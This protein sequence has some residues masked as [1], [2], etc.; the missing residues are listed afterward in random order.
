VHFRFPDPFCWASVRWCLGQRFGGHGATPIGFTLALTLPGVDASW[1][2]ALTRGSD[3]AAL[4]SHCLIGGDT[5]GPLSLT[6]TVFG[7]VPSVLTRAGAQVGETHS[8]WAVS[9]GCGRCLA[10]GAEQQHTNRQLP[11]L[12]ARYWSPMPQLELARP[13]VKASE[14][15]R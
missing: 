9:C 11:M 12:L 15:A 1:L 2:Q 10:A 7:R 6:L 14:G 13:Q 4:R 3:G 8:V 5:R